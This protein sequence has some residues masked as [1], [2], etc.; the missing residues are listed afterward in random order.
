MIEFKALGSATK[1]A[2]DGTLLVPSSPPTS[3]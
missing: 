3:L 1:E 2:L